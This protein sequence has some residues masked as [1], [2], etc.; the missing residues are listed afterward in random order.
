MPD[1]SAIAVTN[2]LVDE[3]NPRLAQP[4]SGQQNAIRALATVQ[5]RK[6]QVL[7]ADIVN[8]GLNP[9][10]ITI[11]MP[12]GG[13]GERFV[14]LDGNRR[15]TALRALENPELLVDAVPQSVYR[16]IRRLALKYRES[17]IR[18]IQ[19]VVF[20]GRGYG[21]LRQFIGLN[22]AIP[23]SREVPVQCSGVPMKPTDSEHARE[24]D[25]MLLRKP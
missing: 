13:D 3:L 18:E 19:C 15:L 2:L 21:Q 7:A 24:A 11:V 1:Y 4:S 16:S 12:F 6:L 14:V 9:S 22:Y 25:L 17:P 10:D 5:G 8:H 20:D 23:A